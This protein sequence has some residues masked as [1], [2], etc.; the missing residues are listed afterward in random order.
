MA[1]RLSQVAS[2]RQIQRL[3]QVQIQA[4]RYLKMSSHDLRQEIYSAAQKNP[5]IEIVSDS[6]E[7]PSSYGADNVRTGVT[8]AAGIEKSQAYQEVL[9]A[10]EDTRESLQEHLLSQFNLIKM[11]PAQAELGS[12]LIY[13]LD[14]NGYH[15]LDPKVFIKPPKTSLKDLAFCLKTI[16]ELEPVGV[17]CVNLE[18]SLL[19]QA[20]QKDDADECALFL[21]DGHFEFLNPPEPSEILKKIRS[22]AKEQQAMSFAVKDYSFLL[23]YE[24][25]DVKNALLF[26]RTLEPMPTRGYSSSPTSYIAPDVFVEKVLIKDVNKSDETDRGTFVYPDTDS[27]SEYCF[28]VKLARG[29]IPEVRIN[30]QMLDMSKNKDMNYDAR[31]QVRENVYQAK[32][33]IAML[34]QRQAVINMAALEIVRAQME[35]FLHGNG[36][37]NILHQKDIA[38]LLKVNE[39]TVSRMANSKYIQCEWGLLPVSYFFTGGIQDVSS[40]RIK[41]A[42]QAIVESQASGSKPLSDQKISIALESQGIK[43][44]RRTVAKYRNQMA[45]ESSYNRK[46]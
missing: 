35:F 42:I 12:A 44:A 19:I 33:F 32:N 27:T 38:K 4:F 10:Q 8:T 3:N 6:Q 11:T 30:Q 13:N 31:Q 23:D 22:F 17:C 21:L 36:H 29:N 39:S 37:L 2:Q 24:I 14:S 40:D 20:R 34:E 16:Q 7:S 26:I 46:K 5:A 25:E 41:A 45:V 9:E 43:C 1:M 28:E 15:I 18:E